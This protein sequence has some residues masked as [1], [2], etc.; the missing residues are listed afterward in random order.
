MP[1]F[2]PRFSLRSGNPPDLLVPKTNL[3][4]AEQTVRLAHGLGRRNV[5]QALSFALFHHYRGM[6][7]QTRAST[8]QADTSG[9]E[10]ANS[11][12][13]RI[14]RSHT[15]SRKGC[16]ECKSRHIRCDERRPLC[17]N[18]EVAER[19]CVFPPPKPRASKQNQRQWQ[20]YHAIQDQGPKATVSLSPDPSSWSN[21]NSINNNT[22]VDTDTDAER[23]QSAIQD[24]DRQTNHSGSHQAPEWP[25][26]TNMSTNSRENMSA[27][28]PMQQGNI[29]TASTNCHP[30]FR[31]IA[32][33]P[34]EASFT[35][36]H[37]ILL[38]HADTVPNL[39]R[40]NRNV[41]DIAIR[42]AV[43]SPYLLDEVLAFTAFHMAHVYPGSAMHLRHL[44]TELQT[45]AL[46]TF[47]RLTET[48]PKD[49]AATAVPRFLF[50]GILGRHVLADTLAHY[51]SDFH[52]FIDR[53]I[54][55]FNINRGIKAITPQ[56]QEY[57]RGS[58]VQPFIDV[59]IEAQNRVTSPG[60]EC[61]PLKRLM[62]D[63]DLSEPSIKACRQAIDVLQ[64]S[65]DMCHGLDEDDYTQCVSKFS[66]GTEVGFIEVL[67]KHRP[68]GLVI[69]AYYGVLLHRCRNFW[70]FN[71]AGA[72][73]IS[74][75]AQ[76]VGSYWQ[77]VLSWP[78]H[79]IEV[80]QGS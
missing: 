19:T 20:H 44:A 13:A 22:G 74:T 35:A 58:E 24:L 37:M 66:V 62:D 73:L 18:C 39:V 64:Q 2:M 60:T 48:I 45:R 52:M 1:H 65:F 47:T 77:G 5:K 55:C 38:R 33:S 56:A 50:S 57:F 6:T 29:H 63:S 72:Y 40:A 71:D 28:S 54:E 16:T 32:S 4:A 8:R 17:A 79:V 61:D 70:A 3:K 41:V 11:G 21:A 14:R 43:E 59:V 25:S 26:A 9:T 42:H 68:E 76:N 75:I 7:R 46:A 27:A 36:Q 78:L 53:F 15:K 34:S 51:R 49:D 31:S 12:A 23:V 67:R 80:E 69:L 30:G 10:T